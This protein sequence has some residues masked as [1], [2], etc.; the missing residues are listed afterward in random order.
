MTTSH[1]IRA[2]APLLQRPSSAPL[3]A[4]VWGLV[5]VVSEATIA[6]TAVRDRLR[7]R[8]RHGI[9][10]RLPGCAARAG[11]AIR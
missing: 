1:A 8:L 4:L 3:T 2:A 5:D 7:H 10:G 9:P 11:A 6:F